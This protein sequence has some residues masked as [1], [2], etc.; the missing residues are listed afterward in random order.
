MGGTAKFNRTLSAT[1]YGYSTLNQLYI[2]RGLAMV[3]IGHPLQKPQVVN[4]T[5][6]Y[7][8]MCQM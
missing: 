3:Q 1:L 5:A 6:N 8:P 2:F 4:T 7:V